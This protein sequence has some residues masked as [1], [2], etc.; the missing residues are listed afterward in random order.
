MGVRCRAVDG[1][2]PKQ[3]HFRV[4]LLDQPENDSKICTPSSPQHPYPACPKSCPLSQAIW[5]PWPRQ[6]ERK[7]LQCFQAWRMGRE[8]PQLCGLFHH[9]GMR[10]SPATG[11]G[12]APVGW[13]IRSWN[14]H[15]WPTQGR[16]MPR[17]MLVQR[18]HQQVSSPTH[19]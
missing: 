10:A 17:M 16:V 12:A 8:R 4:P 13:P 1:K 15:T 14:P 5:D 3:T 18:K 2:L 11:G 6:V 19:L 9:V 7:A